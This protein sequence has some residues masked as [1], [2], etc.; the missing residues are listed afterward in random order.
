MIYILYNYNSDIISRINNI[1]KLV[2]NLLKEREGTTSIYTNNVSVYSA[3]AGGRKSG[4]VASTSKFTA[5]SG[6]GESDKSSSCVNSIS[7]DAFKRS[8]ELSFVQSVCVFSLGE[9][10]IFLKLSACN[11]STKNLTYADERVDAVKV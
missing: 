3:S 4:I 2:I 7:T 9:F 8:E 10:L 11:Q 6:K 5:T 1:N